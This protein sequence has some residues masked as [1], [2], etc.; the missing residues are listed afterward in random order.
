MSELIKVFHA[1]ILQSLTYLDITLVTKDISLLPENCNPCYVNGAVK[2][3]K[4]MINV[5]KI[6]K[7]IAIHTLAKLNSVD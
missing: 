7:S 2:W 6:K 5:Q 3:N 1:H 4:P